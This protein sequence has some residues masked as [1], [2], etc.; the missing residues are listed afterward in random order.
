MRCAML[1]A[2]RGTP[3][4]SLV[5]TLRSLLAQADAHFEHGRIAQARTAGFAWLAQHM[6]VRYHPGFIDR[7]QHWFY[8][9]LYGLERAAL[10]AG[11][12][13]IQGR[14]WYF[15][16]AMVLVGVQGKGGEW[17]GELYADHDIERTAMA[18]LFL[19]L[20]TLPVLTG[21]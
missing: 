18:I 3:V 20:S 13:L 7:Q 16:G 17:P 14:D 11:V 12:A 5:T 6:Q 1:G 10:L 4:P 19:K 2:H 9:Y 8:Y 21:K 15:E